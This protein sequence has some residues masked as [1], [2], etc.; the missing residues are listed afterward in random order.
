MTGLLSLFFPPSEGNKTQYIDEESS[1][2][3]DDDTRINFLQ[4][5]L[6]V[7]QTSLLHMANQSL[8]E[9][10]RAEILREIDSICAE[11][12][13]ITMKIDDMDRVIWS[14]HVPL[15]DNK[16]PLLK[17]VEESF[18]FD[19]MVSSEHGSKPLSKTLKELMPQAEDR[20]VWIQD[21]DISEVRSDS[22]SSVEI[23]TEEPDSDWV[24]WW[25][26]EQYIK[27]EETS[28]V[29]FTTKVHNMI[30]RNF[31][32]NP[33]KVRIPRNRTWALYV[34]GID[35]DS[36]MVNIDS[37]TVLLK[38][39]LSTVLMMETLRTSLIPQDMRHLLDAC[40]VQN[41]SKNFKMSPR[42]YEY[43]K[44]VVSD[45]LRP[46]K[47]MDTTFEFRRFDQQPWVN[48]KDTV[49]NLTFQIHISIFYRF[50]SPSE[51]SEE[52]S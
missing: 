2:G 33:E 23:K 50:F 29:P 46:T 40:T 16:H 37:D 17:K 47:L 45:T 49:V 8:S 51:D 26:D 48:Q 15:A 24:V 28:L 3:G 21:I 34:A 9:S 18:C 20:Q 6:P 38:R 5:P 41:D 44:K 12:G 25:I 30:N 42:F 10:S 39:N 36:L 35:L 27:S 31:N 22:S 4:V 13:V 7:A 14:K 32:W 52:D 1:Y 19:F 11:Q 43:L